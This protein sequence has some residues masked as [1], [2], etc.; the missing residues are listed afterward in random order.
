L[1][2]AKQLGGL[3]V[4]L[5]KMEKMLKDMMKRWWTFDHFDCCSKDIYT[6]KQ[7]QKRERDILVI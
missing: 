7:Q 2:M 5:E 1:E 4:N 3:L 6:F